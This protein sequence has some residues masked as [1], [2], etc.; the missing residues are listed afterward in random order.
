MTTIFWLAASAILLTVAA[1]LL[2]GLRGPERPDRVM[3]VPLVG[4]GG[5]AVAILIGA[6]REEAAYLDVAL[7]FA[8]LAAFVVVAFVRGAQGE[9][10]EK[11]T[12][13]L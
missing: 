5:L 11:E 12:P 7:V 1:A 3:A 4:T 13:Q 6:A 2:R 8:V 9:D 10:P